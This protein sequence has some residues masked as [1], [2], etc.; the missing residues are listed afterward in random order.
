MVNEIHQ[1]FRYNVYPSSGSQSDRT[2]GSKIVKYSKQKDRLSYLFKIHLAPVSTPLAV[3]K[4]MLQGKQLVNSVNNVPECPLI[5]FNRI[6]Y[7][8]CNT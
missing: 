5:R 8:I 2:I 1:S 7:L 6:N 4:M 3:S